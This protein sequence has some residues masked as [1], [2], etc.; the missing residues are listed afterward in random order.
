MVQSRITRRCFR[1]PALVL[2]VLLSLA[3]I[4]TT[5]AEEI[6]VETRVALQLTLENFVESK[7]Q[8]NVYSFF[9]P[10]TA[11][12]SKLKLRRLHPVIFRKD[13]FYLMCADFIDADGKDVLI[14]YIVG[15]HGTNFQIEQEIIGRRSWLT[16]ALEKVF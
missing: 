4:A 3:S 11:E 9:N 14:D 2:M 6:D 8:K 10:D 1:L 7:T 16:K 15:K 13:D 12:V 5:Q